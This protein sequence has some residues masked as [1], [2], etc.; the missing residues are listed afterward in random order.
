MAVHT[1]RIGSWVLR[2]GA[3]SE[4]M[5]AI[6]AFCACSTPGAHSLRKR[7]EGNGHTSSSTSMSSGSS[8]S[9]VVLM[10]W[11]SY[12]RDAVSGGGLGVPGLPEDALRDHVALHLAGAAGDGEAA[13]GQEALLPA[14]GLAVEHRAVRAVERHP[15]FLHALLVLH[16]EQLAHARS[17]PGIDSRERP[18]RGAVAEQGHR[19]RLGDEVPQPALQAGRGGLAAFAATRP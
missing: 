15:H 9:P 17:A 12:R 8:G 4:S 6:H 5:A 10:G 19:L 7:S 16:P 11:S 18:E 14:L 13:G 2:A 1:M 3:R